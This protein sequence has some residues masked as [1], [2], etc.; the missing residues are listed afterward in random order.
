M[1]ALDMPLGFRLLR[2]KK[3]AAKSVS[4]AVSTLEVFVATDE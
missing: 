3:F 2:T 1:N 4:T